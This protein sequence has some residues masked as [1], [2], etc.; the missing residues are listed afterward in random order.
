MVV[1]HPTASFHNYIA[2]LVVTDGLRRCFTLTPG[3]VTLQ[4]RLVLTHTLTHC[5]QPVLTKLARQLAANTHSNVEVKRMGAHYSGSRRDVEIQKT[6]QNMM[7][8]HTE[9]FSQQVWPGFDCFRLFLPPCLLR[10]RNFPSIP[11]A[12]TS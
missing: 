3:S 4:P 12:V 1:H 5:C 10:C 7:K 11:Q 8:S 9:A 6:T 2:V